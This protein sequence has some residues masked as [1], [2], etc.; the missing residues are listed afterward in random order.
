MFLQTLHIYT[1]ESRV[2]L[3]YGFKWSHCRKYFQS[4]LKLFN[5]ELNLKT[6]CLSAKPR[7]SYLINIELKHRKLFASAKNQT[8]QILRNEVFAKVW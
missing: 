6:I 7:V 1:V 2:S 8:R 3:Q 5:I 4:Q